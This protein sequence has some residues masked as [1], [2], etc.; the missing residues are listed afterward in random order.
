MKKAIIYYTD[1]N[2][3]N[4]LAKRCRKTLLDNCGGI[5]IVAVSQKPIRYPEQFGK[6]ILMGEIGRSHLN[7]YRQI[8][9]GLKNTDADVVFMAEHDVLYSPEHFTFEPR[10]T[11]TFYYN[12]NTWF[13]NWKDGDAEKGK[14][15]S[16]WGIRHATSQLV[17]YRDILIENMTLRIKILTEG[18]R[19]RQGQRGACE[20]G[21]NEVNAFIRQHDD[22]IKID[23]SLFKH[24]GVEQFRT[25]IANVDI[26]N[27]Q[28]LTGWRRGSKNTYE[29]PYWATARQALS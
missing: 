20:P 17:C 14:Y 13:L 29:L 11:D 9:E 19:M 4:S 25:E 12:M 26:R 6:Q 3:N 23:K 8:M 2:L 5:P 21:V 7:L 28:N 24:W 10:K 16:P 22:G 18:W 15:S 27:G 1:N